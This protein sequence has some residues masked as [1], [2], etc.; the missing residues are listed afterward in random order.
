MVTQLIRQQIAQALS[1]PHSNRVFAERMREIASAQNLSLDDDAIAQ[2]AAL[3]THYIEDTVNLL[4]ACTIASQA[5]A[6]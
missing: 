6:C 4:D 5:Y 3:A 1:L 2:Y